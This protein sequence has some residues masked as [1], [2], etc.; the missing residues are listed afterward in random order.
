MLDRYG[1]T[2]RTTEDLGYTA[3]FWQAL[4]VAPA[5]VSE[6]YEQRGAALGFERKINA[7]RSTLLEQYSRADRAEKRAV[8]KEIR[9]FNKQYPA[10]IIT[11]DTLKSSLAAR[12]KREDERTGAFYTTPVHRKTLKEI[13][14]FANL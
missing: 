3:L 9:Q 6:A 1:N 8:W 2:I 5:G 7:A 11:A 4:G 12:A 10:W 13:G 14:S